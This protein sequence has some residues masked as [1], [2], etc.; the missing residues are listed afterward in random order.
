[1]KTNYILLE[2]M[3]FFAHH[4][5][6]EEERQ[7][8]NYFTVNLKLGT[9]LSAAAESDNLIDTLNYGVAY[10]IVK[11]EMA[12][13]SKLLEHVA[14]RII[15]AL[16]DEFGRQLASVEVRLSKHNPPL[17]GEVGRATVVLNQER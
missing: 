6:F 15:D 4:G 13:P 7:A 8:G 3:R 11:K 1:M 2:D 5:V 9:S 14:R 17:G 12:V 16:F 10:E